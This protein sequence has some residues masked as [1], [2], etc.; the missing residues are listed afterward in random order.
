MGGGRSGVSADQMNS[1]LN[2][3]REMMCKMFDQMNKEYTDTIKSLVEAMKKEQD[4][5]ETPEEYHAIQEKYENQF[6]Q[7]LRTLKFK[8]IITPK[9]GKHYCFI[10]PTSVGKSSLWNALFE[11]KLEIGLGSCTKE[12]KEI[13]KVGNVTYWDAPGINKDFGFYKPHHLG[14]FNDLDKIFVLFESEI[15][16]VALILKVFK[17]MG[18][19]LVIVRT[20]IDTWDAKH[21]KTI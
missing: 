21:K 2:Q 16:S 20:K 9:V 19:K 3:Q 14:F 7:S 11:L 13:H 1:M 8:E 17:E 12:A 15:E 4:K 6:V 5:A 10:G 18:K